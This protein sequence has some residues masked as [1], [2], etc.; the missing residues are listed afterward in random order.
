MQQP[1]PPPPIPTTTSSNQSRSPPPPPIPT[2]ASSNQSR[3]PPPPP[4][5]T[6]NPNAPP[7]PPPIPNLQETTSPLVKQSISAK[8]IDKQV[9]MTARNLLTGK[10]K[11]QLRADEAKDANPFGR[12]SSMNEYPNDDVGLNAGYSANDGNDDKMVF[13]DNIIYRKN[14]LEQTNKSNR[15][16]PI[17]NATNET[18]KLEIEGPKENNIYHKLN[19][20]VEW[21]CIAIIVHF[22]QFGV[23]LDLAHDVLSKGAYYCL[24]ML[25]IVVGLLLLIARFTVKKKPLKK[26]LFFVEDLKPEDEV[27]GV[28]D[29]TLIILAITSILEGFLFALFCSFCGGKT[30]STSTTAIS[31]V[32]LLSTLQYSSITFL[33]FH[34]IVRP[35]NRCDP[36][37]TM[38]ELD[39]VSVC[40]DALD[41]STFFQLLELNKFSHA[42][43]MSIRFLMSFWYIS[44]GFRVGIMH[45]ALCSP[46]SLISKLILTPVLSLSEIPTVDRTLQGLRFRSTLVIIMTFAELYAIVIRFTLWAKG[47][48]DALQQEMA[49]KNVI[50]LCSVYG[51][52]D[53]YQSTK[54][55]NWNTRDLGIGYNLKLPRR[56]FQMKF[57]KYTFAVC[58]LLEG[59]LLGSVLVKSASISNRWVI[60]VGI[61]LLLVILFLLYCRKAYNH[62]VQPPRFWLLPQTHFVIFPYYLPV[63]FSILMA[64]NLFVGR[65]PYIYYQYDNLQAAAA[66]GSIWNYDFSLIVISVFTVI[67]LYTF[68]KFWSIAIMLFNKKFTACPGNYQAIHDPTIV[69]VAQASMLE[70]A[71]DVLSTAT[72]LSL[73]S[74]NLP[75]SVN[76]A[77][78]MFSL[79]ELFNACVSFVV[80][81]KL[82]NGNE[83]TPLD[84]V[85]WYSYL[86]CLRGTIDFGA[87]VLRVYV[88]YNYGA[89]S[90]VFIIKNLYNL[91]HTAANFANLIG[92]RKYK[93]TLFTEYVPPYYWYGLTAKDWKNLTPL[94]Y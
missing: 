51:A 60:N 9:K 63:I 52:Y 27:D 11:S 41:G 80:Q 56:H 71:V 15:T 30:S 29:W 67:N 94:E 2:T 40:W 87:F 76:G 10:T 8:V 68:S 16:L 48:L 37:R 65:L 62:R 47:K 18:K 6:T 5:P 14:S 4:I 77:V 36:L 43:D 54:Y 91:L 21:L 13:N 86:R 46:G 3:S 64:G 73:A 1:P 92:A 69:M 82:S 44:V 19:F 12:G 49:I 35:S 25:V 33:A 75:A 55:H 50:F 66:E 74:Y 72:L 90:S 42:M 79:L 22:I 93:L 81:V 23:L 83:D 85:I 78:V 34:R 24:L 70:G 26:L 17:E 57:F 53:M 39:V 20:P 89:I 61:D 88:W 84:L 7:P 38:M 28:S 31:R 32:S 45:L 58:Y 59:S